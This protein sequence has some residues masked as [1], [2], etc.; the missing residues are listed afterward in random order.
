MGQLES[1]RSASGA[2]S[3]NSIVFI[4]GLSGSAK[5]T[6]AAMERQF[7]ADPRFD[8]Y[9][10][11]YYQYPTRLIRLPFTPPLPMLA[12]LAHGL[13]TLIDERH[14]SSSVSIVA[15]SL[16]GLIARQYIVDVLKSNRDLL[17]DNLVLIAVPNTGASLANV[18][19]LLS[20]PHFQLKTLAKDSEGLRRLNIDWLGCAADTKLSIKYILG[21]SDRVVPHH[22]GSPY[23]GIDA[24][25]LLI[26]ADHRS[27][28]SPVDIND[29][30][31][32][33][34]SNF[35][36]SGTKSNST[37]Q[38]SLKQANPLLGD[39][40]FD[41]YTPA[42]EQFYY[43]RDFDSVLADVLISSHVWVTGRSGCGKSASLRRAVSL[44]GWRLIHINLATHEAAGADDMVEALTEE[45]LN[46]RDGGQSMEIAIGAANRLRRLKLAIE[47]QATDEVVGIVVEEIP[48]PPAELS[49]FLKHIAT[50]VELL[51]SES[52][53]PQQARL[54]LSSIHAIDDP[55]NSISSKAR[56]MVQ[57]I[58][59]SPWTTTQMLG[60]GTVIRAASDNVISDEALE[61]IVT[62]ADGS[63]RMMKAVFRKFRNGIATPADVD[64]VCDGIRL[65]SI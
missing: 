48:L 62:A 19:S 18:A 20:F 14:A 65:E 60:L 30:R 40:L 43:S 25:S 21:G 54:L 32:L 17:V 31:Y 10:L 5:S 22:S 7:A 39:P 1:A 44:S 46:I 24:A 36:I 34:V 6:W 12:D 33:A 37:R 49:K 35:L 56:E 28:V 53:R 13:R 41:I 38:G 29:I 57:L 59:V 23:K 4:H 42:H 26:E 55:S 8:G 63:P 64:S 9:N 16:G 51:G 2:S 11:D 27:I 58:P 47:V 45:L 50:V 52:E 3:A 61:R 15:H